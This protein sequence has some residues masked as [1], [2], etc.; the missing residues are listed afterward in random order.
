MSKKTKLLFLEMFAA[1]ALFG[2]LL[3]FVD[4][5]NDKPKEETFMAYVTETADASVNVIPFP[6]TKIRKN[7]SLV[8][9]PITGV[10]AGDVIEITYNSE[11]K[12]TNP[13]SID[14]IRYRIIIKAPIVEVVNEPEVEHHEPYV[15]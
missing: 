13:V 3:Y 5:Y 9:V 7:H 6:D 1:L 15:Q 2:V 8:M 11:I 4:T 10:D 12:G 14:V